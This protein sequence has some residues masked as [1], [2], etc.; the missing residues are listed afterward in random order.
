MLASRRPKTRSRTRTLSA[1]SLSSSGAPQLL[2]YLLHVN[3]PCNGGRHGLGGSPAATP[4]TIMNSQASTPTE[5]LSRC[6]P[7]RRVETRRKVVEKNFAKVCH[8]GILCTSS[9]ALGAI[10]TAFCHLEFEFQSRSIEC[11]Y[12]SIPGRDEAKS[13]LG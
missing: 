11:N 7:L 2:H 13:L 3:L 9:V 1:L 12:S 10:Y 4:G 5:V 8:E 6:Q